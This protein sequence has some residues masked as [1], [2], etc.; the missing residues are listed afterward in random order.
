MAEIYQ[1]RSVVEAVEPILS[2]GSP[3][4]NGQIAAKPTRA[5][6][7]PTNCGWELHDPDKVCQRRGRFATK[8]H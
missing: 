1:R 4:T 5:T 7:H 2:T 3:F 6:A 8:S